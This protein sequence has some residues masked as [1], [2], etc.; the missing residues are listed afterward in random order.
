MMVCSLT[1]MLSL[2]KEFWGAVDNI[3]VPFQFDQWEGY[4]L[5]WVQKQC[6]SYE[7]IH[8]NP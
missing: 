1:A 6:F 8:S 2:I 4:I 3:D 7:S 5:T